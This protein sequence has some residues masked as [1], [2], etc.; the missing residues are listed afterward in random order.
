MPVKVTPTESDNL[1]RVDGP[2]VFG[3]VRAVLSTDGVR[4]MAYPD[5]P[6]DGTDLVING[7]TYRGSVYTRTNTNPWTVDVQPLATDTT[8]MR[9]LDWTPPT[10][11]AR[12]TLDEIGQALYPMIFTPANAAALAYQRALDAFHDAEQAR[13]AAEADLAV[14]ERTLR[15]AEINAEPFVRAAL[16][17]TTIK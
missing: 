12:R 14:A 13:D 15:E 8:N 16:R 6:K 3:V 11:F 9:R 5:D 4:V 1:Y 17:G 2:R 10:D 7:V